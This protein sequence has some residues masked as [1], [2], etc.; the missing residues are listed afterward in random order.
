[1]YGNYED[2]QEN[3]NSEARWPLPDGGHLGQGNASFLLLKLSGEH[4]GLLIFF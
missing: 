4:T 1:M 3:G 2:K